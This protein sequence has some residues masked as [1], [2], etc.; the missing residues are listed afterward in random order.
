MMVDS[1]LTMGNLPDEAVRR[2]P[3]AS[4]PVASDSG[5]DAKACARIVLAAE[6][7]G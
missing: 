1:T 4:H 2:L 5:A 6:A 7:E 3:P